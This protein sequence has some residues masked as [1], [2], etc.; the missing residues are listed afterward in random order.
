MNSQTKEYLRSRN[1]A[2]YCNMYSHYTLKGED[3]SEVNYIIQINYTFGLGASEP[4]Y[5]VYKTQ[6]DERKQYVKNGIII[7]FN[8]DKVKKFGILTMRRENKN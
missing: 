3:Y 2:F 6:T 7:E 5:D 4:L 1:Y 8:M